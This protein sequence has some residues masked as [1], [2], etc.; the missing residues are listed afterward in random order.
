M[1][2]TVDT[3]FYPGWTRKAITFSIDDGNTVMDKKF[4]DIMRPVG[5]RGT[6]NLCAHTVDKMSPEE[7]REFYR[8]YE[9]ANHCKYHPMAISENIT[10]HFCEEPFDPSIK[11][12]VELSGNEFYHQLFAA[13]YLGEYSKEILAPSPS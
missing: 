6:F 1:K 4:L 2:H 12:H 7:Y 3:A 5:I 11:D 9:I 10:Y 8:D 13:K